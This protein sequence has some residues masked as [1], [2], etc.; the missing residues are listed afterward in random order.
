[1]SVLQPTLIAG[2]TPYFFD[3]GVWW[4]QEHADEIRK[5]VRQDAWWRDHTQLVEPEEKLPYSPFLRKLSDIG[6]AKVGLVSAPGEFATR[7]GIVDVFPINL[8][9]PIRIEFSGNTVLG[10]MPL[11]VAQKP[12]ALKAPAAASADEYEKLWLAG[13][14]P[15]NFVVHI[16]H[17]IGIFRGIVEREA[18]K[19]FFELEYAPPR[20]GSVPDRLLVPR[21][22]SKRIARYVG[23]E[24]PAVHRLGG[25]VWENTKRHARE[26]A[27]KLAAELAAIYRNRA[28]AVRPSYP[29]FLD[30]ETALA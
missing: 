10:I 2:I 23:F 17:G 5:Q 14:K 24:T 1:M 25:T 15:G 6:Y 20:T 16:N 3:R 26:D 8:E 27:R 9:H 22:Q 30:V 28:H 18:G 21:E 11:P 4:C 29:R 7:G 12:K 13:L 19:E